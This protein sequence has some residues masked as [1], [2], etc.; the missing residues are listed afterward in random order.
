MTALR[1]EA[2]TIREELAELKAEL[3]SLPDKLQAAERQ[4]LSGPADGIKAAMDEK[5]A[6]S[7]RREMLEIAI[8]RAEEAL[9]LNQLRQL[10]SD[11]KPMAELVAQAETAEAEAS[12]AVTR[13]QKT[14][15]EVRARRRK[16][17]HDRVNIERQIQARQ[18]DVANLRAAFK[19]TRRAA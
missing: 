9:I 15:E 14:L 13:A 7:S 1:N 10:E 4:I 19:Q 17:E 11:L 18:N 3:E 16:V 6:L 2:E 8:F 5:T 12:D